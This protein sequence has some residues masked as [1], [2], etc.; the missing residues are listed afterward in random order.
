MRQKKQ[1]EALFYKFDA[2]GSGGLDAQELVEL[3]NQNG[4]AVDETIINKLFGDDINF[5][6]DRFINITQNKEE[7]QRYFKCFRKIKKLMLYRAE[8]QRTYMPTTFDETMV[9]FG[10]KLERKRIL[11]E[12]RGQITVL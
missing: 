10:S 2:D 12:V 5:T 8:G 6:L 11:D 3:Y 1:I 4:V 9:E 7:L